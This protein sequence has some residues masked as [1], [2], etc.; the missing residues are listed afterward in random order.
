MDVV[1]TE[2]QPVSRKRAIGSR[3]LRG[4]VVPRRS[5]TAARSA[6]ARAASRGYTQAVDRMLATP[7]RVTSAAEGRA[8]LAADEHPEAFAEHVQK[9]AIAAVP[10]IRTVRRRGR[11]V[12]VPSVLVASTALSAGMAMRRGFRELQVLAALVEH[13]IEEATGERADTALVNAVAVALYL[14]PKHE[15][16]P[17]RGGLPLARLG[18]HWALH[19]AFGR[20][21]G[22]AA[23][24]ALDAAERLDAA[25]QARRWVAADDAG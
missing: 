3:L 13:R 17:A 5:V 18:R 6:A 24:H 12:R 25:A 10:V 23:A 14:D 15:P 21:T 4:G 2:L 16:Q 19:G 11:S 9:V 7:E 22:R 8:L 1:P 20:D